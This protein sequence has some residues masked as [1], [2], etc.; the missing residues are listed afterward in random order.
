VLYTEGNTTYLRENGSIWIEMSEN[1]EVQ[2]VV[3]DLDYEEASL[4]PEWFDKGNAL[5]NAGSTLVGLGEK[6]TNFLR[7]GQGAK[8]IARAL[9]KIGVRVGTQATAKVLTSTF[10][11][12]KSV[13]G[14]LGTV[15]FL[16]STTDY[17]ANF[18]D[19]NGYEH[20][21]YWIGL[22]VSAISVSVLIVGIMYGGAQLASYLYNGKSLEENVGKQL[23]L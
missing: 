13:G 19:K 2:S 11:G 5:L 10:N 7:Q 1:L 4:Y 14:A 15:G 21:N 18:S 17:V 20:A 12:F 9:S 22:G 23:G 6:G 8:H 3:D 16:A